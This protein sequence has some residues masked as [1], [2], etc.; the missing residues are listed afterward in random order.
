[1]PAFSL[2]ESNCKLSDEIDASCA[3]PNILGSRFT[4]RATRMRRGSSRTGPGTDC[5]DTSVSVRIYQGLNC[6]FQNR[7]RGGDRTMSPL[8]QL[9]GDA[10]QLF[11]RDHDR[12]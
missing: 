1:V 12:F 4:A 7:V 9:F 10:T 2:A 11:F 3:E 8:N 6:L 5:R